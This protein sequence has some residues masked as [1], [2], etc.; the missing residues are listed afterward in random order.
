MDRNLSNASARLRA[1]LL[2]LA[3]LA[4]PATL[5]AGG[6][7]QVANITGRHPNPDRPGELLATAQ[8]VRWDTRCLP[9]GLRVNETLNPIPNPLGPPVLTLVQATTAFDQAL[10]TWRQVPTSFFEATRLGNTNNP[11]PAGFDMVNELTFNTNPFTIDD[12]GDGT[13]DRSRLLA[14]TAIVALIEDSQLT[15][16]QDLDGDGDADVAAGLDRCQDADGDGD[17]ELPVGFYPAGTLLDADV[18]FNTA[19]SRFTVGDAQVDDLP[20]SVDLLALATHELGHVQGLGH[21]IENQTSTRDGSAPVMHAF[22]SPNDRV[23]ELQARNLHSDDLAWT[24][25]A[26]PEGT[27]AQGP[28]A[29]QRGDVAFARAYGLLRGEAFHGGQ[30]LPLVGASVAAIDA[31]TGRFVAAGYSGA[32][33]LSYDPVLQRTRQ[34]EPPSAGILGGSWLIPVP[35]GRYLLNLEPTEGSP[36]GADNVNF[37]TELGQAAGQF[38]FFEERHDGRRES[39]FELEVGA[40]EEFRVQSGRTT[41]VPPFVTN[42]RI[43]LGNSAPVQASNVSSAALRGSRYAVRIPKQTLVDAYQGDFLLFQSAEFLMVAIA[44]SEAPV[45]AEALLTT[46]RLDAA[47]QPQIDLAQPL[48]RQALLVGQ[49]RD[50]SAFVFEDPFELSFEIAKGL[51][52]GTIEDLFLVLQVPTAAPRENPS[53]RLSLVGSVPERDP[54][55]INS[56]IAFDGVTFARRATDNFLFRL[57]AVPLR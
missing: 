25:F 9:L 23:A 26:Y 56:Y 18:S 42:V 28:P 6:F 50:F 43:A 57:V 55:R 2:G 51:H 45:F 22:L 37:L 52:D 7:L 46:G 32:A 34:L 47:G 39:S 24:S 17:F 29:L 54:A 31:R 21:A 38:D 35:Q 4:A 12:N 1:H 41:S 30:K 10:A 19:L 3:L 5:E 15:A 33:R 53:G 27:A 13:A 48:R 40:G 36:V 16:G 44:A 49:D 11:G 8:D 14:F 20:Q